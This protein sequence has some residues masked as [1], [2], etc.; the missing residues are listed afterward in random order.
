MACFYF[1][2]MSFFPFTCCPHFDSVQKRADLELA[3]LS[4]WI[5]WKGERKREAN[6]KSEKYLASWIEIQTW[7]ELERCGYSSDSDLHHPKWP[8]RFILGIHLTK[9]MRLKTAPNAWLNAGEDVSTKVNLD[10]DYKLPLE[11]VLGESGPRSSFKPD[12]PVSGTQTDSRW[13]HLGTKVQ[14]P[15]RHLEQDRFSSRCWSILLDIQL[16]FKIIAQWLAEFLWV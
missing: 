8:N 1:H 10:D 14:Q 12:R 13:N 2:L 9:R 4:L 3:K 15:K 6:N 16:R 11:C 7:C 5:Y